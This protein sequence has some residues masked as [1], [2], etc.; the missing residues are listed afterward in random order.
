MT[1][2]TGERWDQLIRQLSPHLPARVHD[3]TA[4]KFE[5]QLFKFTRMSFAFRNLM[6]HDD[7]PF[8]PSFEENLGNSLTVFGPQEKFLTKTPEDIDFLTLML[9]RWAQLKQRFV[10]RLWLLYFLADCYRSLKWIE[11]ARNGRHFSQ[12]KA[13]EGLEIVGVACNLQQEVIDMILPCGESHVIP[14][15]RAGDSM[16]PFY[17]WI[18]TGLC[19]IFSEPEWLS[20]GW[21]LPV[22][23]ENMWNEQALLILGYAEKSMERVKLEAVI[24]G[25]VVGVVGSQFSSARNR[26]RVIKLLRSIEDKGFAVALSIESDLLLEWKNIQAS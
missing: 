15:K 7:V 18:L 11:I 14:N 16:I 23:P 21:E 13:Q 19:R 9:E 17:R 5:K 26:E 25:P 20:H 2:V 12:Q 6:Y 8:M 1:D 10:R 3:L 24:Y 4:N 22:M